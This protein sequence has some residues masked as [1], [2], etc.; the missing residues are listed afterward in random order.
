MQKESCFSTP[1]SGTAC[2]S[3]HSRPG[4][5]HLSEQNT[6][7]FRELG[8]YSKERKIYITVRKAS[9]EGDLEN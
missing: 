6:S 5:L 9:D 7:I 8:G 1:V 3:H 4:P 2:A